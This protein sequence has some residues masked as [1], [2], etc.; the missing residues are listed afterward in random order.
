MILCEMTHAL[1]AQLVLVEWGIGDGTNGPA[2]NQAFSSGWF[3]TWRINPEAV[4]QPVS[5]QRVMTNDTS[6]IGAGNSR[7]AAVY[8]LELFCR[9]GNAAGLPLSI[10]LEQIMAPA[11]MTI[12]FAAFTP[13]Q[14]IIVESSTFGTGLDRTDFLSRSFRIRN[15]NVRLAFTYPNSPATD[16]YLSAVL[17]SV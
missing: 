1:P 3:D 4:V 7:R 8:F 14:T 9:H 10:S 13:Q 6:V 17:R 16:W 5:G 15:R 11:L 12:A 2:A